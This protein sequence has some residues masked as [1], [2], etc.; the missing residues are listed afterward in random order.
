M[1]NIVRY[2]L[3]ILFILTLLGLAF[4]PREGKIRYVFWAILFIN[5]GI[6]I[7]L[8][9]EG[10]RKTHKIDLLEKKLELEKGT[11]RDFQAKLE[12]VFSGKWPQDNKPYPTRILSPVNQEYYIVLQKSQ[13]PEERKK[14]TFFASEEY[15]FKDAGEGKALFYARVAVHSGDNPL[16][17]LLPELIDYDQIDIHIP[18]IRYDYIENQILLI[19]NVNID[20]LINGELLR[21]FAFDKKNEVPVKSMWVSFALHGDGIFSNLTLDNE[22]AIIPNRH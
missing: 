22:R 2:V 20:F 19:E 21:T 1:P 9:I 5:V 7:F 3:D 15:Q 14:I 17:K 18:L 10:H 8:I 12:I 16:G 13:S 11:I 4:V 6:R